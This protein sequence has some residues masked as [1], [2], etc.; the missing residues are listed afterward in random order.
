MFQ[1]AVHFT[2]KIQSCMSLA[3]EALDTKRAS[4]GFKFVVFIHTQCKAVDEERKNLVRGLK[5]RQRFDRNI[6]SC[7]RKGDENVMHDNL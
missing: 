3:V 4:K 1:S 2:E 5:I 7:S 6:K